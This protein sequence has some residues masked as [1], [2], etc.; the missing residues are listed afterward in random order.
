MPDAE[1]AL[2]ETL[3][4]AWRG[5]AGLR[6]GSSARSWLYTIATNVCRTEL[7]R[8]RTRVLPRDLS[9]AVDGNVP[10][11]R[12]MAE[13]V[14]LDPY[15]DQPPEGKASPDAIYEQHEGIELAFVA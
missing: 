12:P 13:S 6:E 1:D 9:P 8:R 14:W 2:Q 11:G 7:A 15:P 5:I 4:R 3:L 10:P